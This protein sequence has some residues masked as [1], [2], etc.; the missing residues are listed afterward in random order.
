M[1]W[2]ELKYK[3]LNIHLSDIYDAME[4]HGSMP[5]ADIINETK[6][7]VSAISLWLRPKFCFFVT[8]GTLN[9]ENETR[10][11]QQSVFHIGKI[12]G[13]QLH[14]SEAYAIFVA[15]AGVEFE[16]FQQALVKEG[17]MVKVFIANA[18]G[19]V[20]A[21]KCTDQMEIAVQ[22]S[23][24]KLNWHHTNRFSPGYCGWN[25][26]EQQDLFSLFKEKGP[27]GVHL[28]ESS[29]MVPIKSVSGIIGI[30]E[31]VHKLDY[32]CGLCDFSKCYRNKK[33][34]TTTS[35]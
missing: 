3:D 2:K 7:I 16:S 5:D 32:A 29:L 20:I 28:T 24:G 10:I 35:H 14:K 30:G 18:I 11:I 23:I 9:I 8:Y 15:T 12:I 4:Y 19:S 1:S 6:T 22:N 34:T 25:V 31:N 26:S 17:D 27:C 13:H 33:R 21:E